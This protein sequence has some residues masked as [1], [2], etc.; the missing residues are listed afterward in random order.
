MLRGWT[1][2]LVFI[3]FFRQLNV[4]ISFSIV[5]LDMVVDSVRATTILFNKNETLVPINL[6]TVVER[7]LVKPGQFHRNCMSTTTNINIERGR[8]GS[9]DTIHKSVSS[10]CAKL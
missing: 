6:C 9:T 2:H 5:V 8:E 4:C 1:N 10:I 7:L 3:K